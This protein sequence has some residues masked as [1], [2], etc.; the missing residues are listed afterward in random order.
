MYNQ[1]RGSW[2]YVDYINYPTRI[3]PIGR[4]DSI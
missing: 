3:F 2:Q 1:L 4:L